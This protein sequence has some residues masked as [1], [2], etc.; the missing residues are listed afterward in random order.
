MAKSYQTKGKAAIRAFLQEQQENG[1]TAAEVHA[2]LQRAGME[3]NLTTVYRNLERMTADGI[4]LKYKSAEA[5]SFIYQ[6]AKE[7]GNCGAHLH[8]QCKRCGKIFHLEC[9]FMEEIASHLWRHHGFQVECDGSVL[10]GVCKDCRE[11]ETK[12]EVGEKE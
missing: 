6:Y 7:H 2:H 8:M 4:L 1:K 10:N 12:K 9:K 11:T 3:V 5:D